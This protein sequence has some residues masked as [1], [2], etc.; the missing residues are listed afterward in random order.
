MRIPE[1]SVQFSYN[2]DPFP[3]VSDNIVP[4]GSPIH[5]E[6]I[7]YACLAAAELDIK[8]ISGGPMFQQFAK[9]LEASISFDE[10]AT[11][12]QNLGYNSDGAHYLSRYSRRK[13]T[14]HE[15]VLYTGA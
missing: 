12:P 2:I 10:R 4:F 5:A 8:G 13:S 14:T 3:L 1:T 7:K 15:G 11:S 9:L 6:T